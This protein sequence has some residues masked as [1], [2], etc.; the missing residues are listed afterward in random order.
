MEYKPE[1]F[2]KTEQIS[3][4]VLS[5]PMFLELPEERIV[6]KVESLATALK[7]TA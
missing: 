4:Q 5:L 1:P 6:R 3:A 7:E 2:P